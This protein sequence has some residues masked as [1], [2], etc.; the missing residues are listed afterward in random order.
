MEVEIDFN[1]K[2]VLEA[3]KE[4][5]EFWSGADRLLSIYN[6]DYVQSFLDNLAIPILILIFILARFLF[7]LLTA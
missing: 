4:Q 3:C 6:G 7:I 2:D 1:S 5:V